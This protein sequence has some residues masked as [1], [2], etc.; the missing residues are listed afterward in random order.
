MTEAHPWVAQRARL[1]SQTASAVLAAAAVSAVAVVDI[2]SAEVGNPLA[3]EESPLAAVPCPTL[4]QSL[5]GIASPSPRPGYS[6]SALDTGSQ[7]A[8]LPIATFCVVVDDVG[9]KKIV[10]NDEVVDEPLRNIFDAVQSSHDCDREH[11]RRFVNL[12]V[13]TYDDDEAKQAQENTWNFQSFN[14]ENIYYRSS[15]LPQISCTWSGILQELIINFSSR[16]I[17]HRNDLSYI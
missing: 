16:V 9:V 2:P 15:S 7:A 4:H 11:T 1:C 3:E 12:N 13:P 6:Q 17:T 8:Q 5:A 10:G 14:V